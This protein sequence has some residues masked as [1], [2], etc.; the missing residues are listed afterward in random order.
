[1]VKELG[2]KELDSSLITFDE[3]QQDSCR[4]EGYRKRQSAARMVAALCR[5]IE[6]F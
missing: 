6:V 4:R 5:A 2:A 1:M 3:V